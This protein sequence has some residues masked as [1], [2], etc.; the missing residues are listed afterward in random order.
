MSKGSVDRDYWSAVADEWIAW[1][2]LPDHDAFW[3]Y[4]SALS[5]FIGKGNGAAL[6]V[7]CGEG[8]VSRELK[9]LGYHVTACDAV[10]AM[11]AAAAAAESAD[12]YAVADAAALPLDSDRFDLVVAYNML[13]DVENVPAVLREIRR[14]LRP[15]GRLVLSLVHP[16]RNR[17]RFVNTAPDAPFVLDGTYY[18][19]ERFEGEEKLDGVRVR[20]TG[21]WSQPLETYVDA[22]AGAGLA[23]TALRE[24]L[25][26]QRDGRNALQQWMRVPLFLWVEARPLAW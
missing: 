11:V 19:R 21:W 12:D 3:S 4:R 10:D 9:T 17:G 2:R 8:R 5:G 6:D 14:V 22:L 1:A 15:G 20:F 13:M 18:G 16:F 25:P 24:P 7:G 26:E 23:I